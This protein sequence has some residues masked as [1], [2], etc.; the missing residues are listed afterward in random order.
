MNPAS[1]RE[2]CLRP[3][4]A[5]VYPGLRPGEW[6]PASK[7]RRHRGPR[8]ASPPAGGVPANLRLPTLPVSWWADSAPAGGAPSPHPG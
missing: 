7:G 2:V 8:P 3:E 1:E 6:V 5:A 4:Y